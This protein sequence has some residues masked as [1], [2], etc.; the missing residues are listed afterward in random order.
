MLPGGELRGQAREGAASSGRQHAG[1]LA[2]SLAE[3]QP[4]VGGARGGGNL[5]EQ[6]R[7]VRGEAQA[8]VVDVAHQPGLQ[9]PRARGRQ[10]IDAAS[11]RPTDHAEHALE[12]RVDHAAHRQ[13][14][15]CGLGSRQRHHQ[16]LA[17]RG[18]RPELLEL[19]DRG[20]ARDTRVR[21]EHGA[22][23]AARDARGDT[24]ASAASSTKAPPSVRR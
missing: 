19:G 21:R 16:H 13:E 8:R 6:G 20:D 11:Q 23:E 12:M 2:R 4:R 14:I 18:D 1:R 3:Q 5:T 17:E 9:L 24:D 7:R 10:L 15:G 22:R